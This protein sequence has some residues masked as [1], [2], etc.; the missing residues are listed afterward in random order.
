MYTANTLREQI[1]DFQAAYIRCIDTHQLKDWPE[2]IV[3]DC[4][5]SVTTLENHPQALPAGLTRANS[6]PIPP[7]PVPA[8]QI[9]ASCAPTR[10]RHTL[11]QLPI[12]PRPPSY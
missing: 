3:S 2:F 6:Q 8:R 11:H 9:P 7:D 12:A 1:A 10:Y 4:L 5:N